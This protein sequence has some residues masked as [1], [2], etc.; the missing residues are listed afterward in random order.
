MS[1]TVI[2][3]ALKRTRTR[4]SRAVAAPAGTAVGYIRVSTEEQKVSRASIDAQRAAIDDLAARRGWTIVAWFADEGISGSK[5]PHE[6]QGLADALDAVQT[7]VAERLIVHK[8]DRLSRKFRDSVDLMETAAEEDWPLYVADIDADLTTQNGKLMSRMLAVLAEHERERIRERTREGLAA[9]RAQGV[10]LGRPSNLPSE[11]VARIVGERAAGATYT[12]IAERLIADGVP[13]AQGG[14]R[15]W[16]AT[17]KAVL[18]GQDAA[19][20]AKAEVTR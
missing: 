1:Q 10:R 12:A 4:R 16:P 2:T 6:R 7:G 3:E 11:I 5:G 17:V 13:T 9:K 14:A 8:I 18:A 20:V 15:W 19:K